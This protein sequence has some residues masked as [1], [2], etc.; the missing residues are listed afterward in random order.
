M[1]YVLRFTYHCQIQNRKSKIRNPWHGPLAQLVEHRTFNPV[2][3]GS[4]PVRPTISRPYRLVRSRTLAFQASNTGSNPVGDAIFLYL[5][6]SGLAG[7]SPSRTPLFPLILISSLVL[8]PYLA[9]R[10]AVGAGLLHCTN[11]WHVGIT[12]YS[13]DSHHIRDGENPPR[14]G[15]R[16]LV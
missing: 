8:Q 14:A 13:K 4:I 12:F 15:L 2:A 16:F 11:G 3:T 7:A 1:L 9:A 10:A 6:L 5:A